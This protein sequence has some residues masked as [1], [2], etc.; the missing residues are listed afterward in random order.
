VIISTNLI[1]MQQATLSM[2][3]ACHRWGTTCTW[4]NT[5]NTMQALCNWT[6]CQPVQIL[7]FFGF[8]D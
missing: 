4:Q 8:S 5:V 7:R 2:C 6:I 3:W 1:S